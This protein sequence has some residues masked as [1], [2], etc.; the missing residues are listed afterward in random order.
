M[1][2]APPIP[3]KQTKA[4]ERKLEQRAKQPEPTDQQ[5]EEWFQSQGVPRKAVQP[6]EGNRK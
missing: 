6:K 5:I 1:T 2:P 4:I 3:R